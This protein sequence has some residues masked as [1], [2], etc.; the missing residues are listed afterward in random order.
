VFQANVNSSA[1]WMAI[2]AAISFAAAAV[3]QFAMNLAHDRMGTR[4]KA[5]YFDKL[6]DQ[7][8]GYFDMKRTGE[9]VNELTESMEVIQDTYSIKTGMFLQ[10]LIQ[11]ILG[12]ILALNAG[13]KMA[14]VMLSCAPLLAVLLGGTG[15]LVQAFSKWIGVIS[16]HAAS[17]A[18]EVISSMRTVRSMDGEEREKSRFNNKLKRANIVYLFKATALGGSLGSAAFSIWGVVALSFWYGGKLV[19][20]NEMT[21]GE[22][23]QVFGFV[24][25]GVIGLSAGLQILPDFGK[26]TASAIAL[27]KVIRRVPALRPRGGVTPNKIEGHIV[28]KDVCFSYPTRPNVQVLKNFNLTITPGQ[29]VALVGASGSGKSTIVGLIEKFYEADSGEIILDGVNLKDID[30]RWLHRNIGIV[31]QE[32]TLFA[33]SIKNNITYA[34]Q[35][36]GRSVTD[37]EI[38]EA[39]K[40]ANAH[41]FIM[42]LPD[43]YNTQLGE[44]G[45][46]L[47]GGQK[48]RIAI[49]RAMIQNPSL[50]LLDE[51]TSALDTQSEATV[52]EALNRLMKGRTTIVIAHRLSTV[53][54]SDLIVVLSK[55]EMREKGRHEEL[56]KIPNGYYWKLAH[57][58]MMFAEKSRAKMAESST[59]GATTTD[60]QI[61]LDEQSNTL[62]ESTSVDQL[63]DKQGYEE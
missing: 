10:N 27:L 56:L 13:W 48:Q 8:I 7:E 19:L 20:R 25:M 29:A 4:L 57:K 47:S 43:N 39:A 51:A 2:I 15:L 22:L 11:A 33:T 34:I 16:G 46:S 61:S 45:V 41:E 37:E 40:A 63:L 52:Q 1:M 62:P 44:R 38:Y 60:D 31:T 59:G 14:L 5:A 17:V 35:G 28:F 3:Q 55:G 54:D 53:V 24:L 9:L 58:Q 6:L 26:A 36:T 50:L 32:P 49:A 12:I 42:Q 30:P 23:F 18:N 21:V